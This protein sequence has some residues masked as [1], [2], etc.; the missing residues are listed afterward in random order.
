[1]AF[2]PTDSILCLKMWRGV[3]EAVR[4]EDYEVLRVCILE[5]HV[6]NEKTN[7]KTPSGRAWGGVTVD[8]KTGLHGFPELQ[9]LLTFVMFRDGCQAGVI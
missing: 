6:V 9:L 2:R 5:D 1:V 8:E 7:E 3:C 4:E